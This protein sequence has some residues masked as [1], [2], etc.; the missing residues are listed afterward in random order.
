MD[1]MH[2]CTLLYFSVHTAKFKLN[3]WISGGMQFL[4]PN[5]GY[6]KCNHVMR[7]NIKYETI[8]TWGTLD[9]ALT[10][11]GKRMRVIQCLLGIS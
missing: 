2:N 9:C 11:F 4:A 7:H 10:V 6:T 3:E 1:P 8:M 5:Q